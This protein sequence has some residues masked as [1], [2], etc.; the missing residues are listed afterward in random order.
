MAVHD[1]RCREVVEVITDFLEGTLEPDVRDVFERHLAMCTWCQDYMDQMRGTMRVVGR[2]RR[3]DVPA[4]LVDALAR[5]F[6]TERA[7]R[8]D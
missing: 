8:T 2:L 3:D 1:I 4:D 7:G 5:T 6:R